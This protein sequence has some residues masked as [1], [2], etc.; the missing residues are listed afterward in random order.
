VIHLKTAADG[1]EKYY[2]LASNE[3][4]YETASEAI[5]TDHRIHNAWIGHYNF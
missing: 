4:R 1:A 5:A 2:D 3:A